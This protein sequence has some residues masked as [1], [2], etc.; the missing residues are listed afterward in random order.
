MLL[1]EAAQV[2]AEQVQQVA[3]LL[4]AHASINM[5]VYYFWTV[6]V[7]WLIHVGFMTYETGCTRRKNLMHT[8]MKNVLTIAVVTISF[9]FP[10]WWL[11]WSLADGFIPRGSA[12]A[13]TA[14]SYPWGPNMGP[15]LADHLSGVF[16]AA[17]LLF[18]WTTASIMS[19]ACIERI[20]L[21]AYLILA[22]FLGSWVWII[23][24]A[25]GW[26]ANGWMVRGFG[27][28]DTIASGVVHGV[29]GAF[30]LGV[31]INLGRR[32]GKFKPDGTPRAVPLH[33]Q[34]MTLQGLMLIFV[35]FWGFYAACLVFSNAPDVIPG[36]PPFSWGTIYAD[37]T[38]LSS[39][40]F[41]FVMQW[42]GGA[43]GAYMV[44]KR[45]PFWTASG[46]LA[47]VIAGSAGA[48]EYYP[49]LAFLVGVIGALGA[50]YGALLLERKYK[51][52]D[53]V[54][55]VA[56]H[57]IAGFIG[58]LLVGVFLQGY[59]TGP[60]DVP[61]TFLGQVL[62]VALFIIL[63]FVPGLGISW[64]LDKLGILRIPVEV[65]LV[66]QDTMIYGDQY[67][68]FAPRPLPEPVLV[69]LETRGR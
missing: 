31:L 51:V 19:G 8:V 26:S 65:E 48:T 27:Y 60:N 23:D 42:S 44:S 17:F 37:P 38:T 24:A 50:Y 57:G 63:G 66:G 43:I 53:A 59:P 62:G 12:D 5:E 15:N 25:W 30:A 16:W 61:V 7:M 46:A 32:V 29:A 55:A 4:N 22:S 13:L 18:C 20:R 34:W 14:A 68:E 54:G 52:D 35:G 58:V 10:G 56:V 41:N 64:I 39:L 1:Q 21:G 9:Y 28:H 67:P 40:A 11:Y 33:N 49:P 2:T 3:D 6:V 36:G 69:G 47:G 45:D